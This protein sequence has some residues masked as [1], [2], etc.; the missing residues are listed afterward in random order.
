[1]CFSWWL[2][3]AS[4]HFW[5]NIKGGWKVKCA[6][7]CVAFT[8]YK[9]CV[10]F[11]S[12]YP[13]WLLKETD[14]CCKAGR[15]H[16]ALTSRKMAVCVWLCSCCCRRRGEREDSVNKTLALRTSC[17]GNFSDMTWQFALSYRKKQW[18]M[19][20]SPSPVSWLLF[21][22][23]AKRKTVPALRNERATSGDT[24][25]ALLNRERRIT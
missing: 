25:S 18:W 4:W 20:S 17:T 24:K 1:M 14:R 5:L 9:V 8:V 3:Y 19:L 16:S 2:A 15:T 21:S 7:A 22:R 23:A 13:R 12:H 10:Y 11:S 6:Y